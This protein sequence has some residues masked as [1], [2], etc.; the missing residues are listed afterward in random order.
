MS[1]IR[2]ILICL[3]MLFGL[4]ACTVPAEV[5]QVTRPTMQ[6][7]TAVST[8]VPTQA[9]ETAVE[10]TN[11]PATPE[12]TSQPTPLPATAAEADWLIYQ[13]DFYGYTIS[14]PPD[15]QIATQ[16]ITGFPTDELPEGM[17]PDEY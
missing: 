15:A 4:M 2:W 8:I 11:Q 1:Q 7:A 3:F 12:P 16:G 13:N 10:P 6:T 9:A 5:V 14:Y 17:S